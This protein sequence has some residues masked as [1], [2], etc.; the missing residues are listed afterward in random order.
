MNTINQS[1]P[2]TTSAAADAA[3]LQLNIETLSQVSIGGQGE[4]YLE[5]MGGMEFSYTASER[6]GAD[7]LRCSPS[8]VIR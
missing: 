4:S 7:A 2:S 3:S 1:S 6:G 8:M 5:G